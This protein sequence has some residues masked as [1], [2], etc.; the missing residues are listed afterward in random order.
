MRKVNKRIKSAWSW[1][2]LCGYNWNTP[3]GRL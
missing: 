2:S 3:N 1:F